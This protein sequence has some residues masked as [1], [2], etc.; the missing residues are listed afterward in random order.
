MIDTRSSRNWDLSSSQPYCDLVDRVG[1]MALSATAS[2]MSP[3]PVWHEDDLAQRL[4]RRGGSTKTLVLDEA[5]FHRTLN[6]S[7][8]NGRH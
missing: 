6:A 7:H 2:A 3:E 8:R 1:A 4:L 5:N